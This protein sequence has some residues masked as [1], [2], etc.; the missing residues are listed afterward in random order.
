M[1]T[2]NGPPQP[3]AAADHRFRLILWFAMF[4]ALAMYYLVMRIA[5]PEAPTADPALPNI[6]VALSV[7]MAGL[8]IPIRILVARRNPKNGFILGLAFCEAAALYG[9]VVWYISGSHRAYYCL[10]AGAVGMLL[11]IPRRG[12]FAG[13]PQ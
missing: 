11:H 10:L 5:T 2:Q 1:D 7:V 8:S 6:L 12:Q 9:V 4:M 3:S 13:S